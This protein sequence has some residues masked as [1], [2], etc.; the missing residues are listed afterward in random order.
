MSSCTLR[1]LAPRDDIFLDIY[2]RAPLRSG[3]WVWFN[4]TQESSR[5]AFP[6]KPQV[7]ELDGR[8][9]P[10]KGIPSERHS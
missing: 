9:P 8:G 2:S 1:G 7:C 10:G 5:L 4:I 3:M 6:K